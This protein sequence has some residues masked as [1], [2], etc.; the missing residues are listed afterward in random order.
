MLSPTDQ[1]NNN[2]GKYQITP[3]R[4][5][6]AIGDNARF[7]LH[8]Y[9]A[10]PTPPFSRADLLAAIQRANA[11][12]RT[13]HN[14]IAGIHIDRPEVDEIVAWATG[15]DASQRLGMLLD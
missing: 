4:F 10:P 8:I 1:T 15:A 5:Q 2:P 13:C 14:T 6:G 7:D 12:L 3:D 9:Q 11:D